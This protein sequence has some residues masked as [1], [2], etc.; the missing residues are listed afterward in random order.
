MDVLPSGHFFKEL[1]AVHETGYFPAIFS[2][3][4]KWEQVSVTHEHTVER[5][6]LHPRCARQGLSPHQPSV[7]CAHFISI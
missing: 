7:M 6:T 1:Q 3:E 5:S 2:P 4:D